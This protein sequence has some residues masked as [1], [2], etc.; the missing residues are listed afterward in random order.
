MSVAENYRDVLAR[1]RAAER[2]AGRQ[3]GE[4]KLIAV[5]KTK[6]L[7]M[8]DEAVAAGATDF[9]ENYVQE[10]SEKVLQRPGLNW[11]FIG[12][13][14]TNKAKDVIGR[15][16]LIHSV[17][18]EK[19]ASALDQLAAA[20]GVKQD[21]LA[22]V[23]IGGELS[24]QGVPPTDALAFVRTLQSFANLRV[25]GLMCLP[26]LRTSEAEAR[27]DF[28]ELREL[29]RRVREDILSS[30]AAES[31]D[32]LSMGTTHDFEWAILEGAT[33]VRVGTAI[34][35]RREG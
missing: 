29:G 24:K 35:G 16:A 26:P 13:L 32:V 27:A 19:L 2:L 5:S 8:I 22:Q 17:D 28:A 21:I 6:P 7:S 15:F 33:H 9:G 23:R 10:A 4:V 14:Q 30:A 12:S 1:V 31:F 20:C 34:F 3:E 18:R 25:R 11:H